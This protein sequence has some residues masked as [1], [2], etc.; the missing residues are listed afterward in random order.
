MLGAGYKKDVYEI[1]HNLRNSDSSEQIEQMKSCGSR[2]RN[3]PQMKYT[4]SIEGIGKAS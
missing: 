1:V 3:C 2:Y 4:Q